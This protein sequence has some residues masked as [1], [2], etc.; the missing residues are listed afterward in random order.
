[1]DGPKPH[2]K[3]KSR[4]LTKTEA[5]GI[6]AVVVLAG[7]AYLLY[8]RPALTSNIIQCGF[9]QWGI[10]P[11]QTQAGQS[12]TTINATETTVTSYTTSTTVAQK[13]GYVAY[14]FTTYSNASVL[15]PILV[16]AGNITLCTYLSTTFSINSSKT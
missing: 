12:F 15:D 3:R 10:F 7:G 6:L 1:M 11:L 2:S 8:P 9:T 16:Y 5:V 4:L 14:T 13:P